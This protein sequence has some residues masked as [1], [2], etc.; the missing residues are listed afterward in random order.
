MG[1]IIG[2]DD[3]NRLGWEMSLGEFLDAGARRHSDKMFV[4]ISGHKVSYREFQFGARQTASMFRNMGIGHGD[5]VCLLLP[6]CL[7]FLLCWFGLSILGAITVPINTAYKRNEVAHILNHTGAKILVAHESLFPVGGDAAELARNLNHKLV[8]GAVTYRGKSWHR[9][10]DSLAQADA[11]TS[12]PEISP[13][14]IS[15]LVYTSGTTGA[16]KG[17]QVTHQM[18]VAAGQGFAHWTHAN[19]QDRFF[20]FL[21]FCHANPQYYS[22]MGTLAVGATLVVVD[23]FNASEFWYQARRAKATVAT[24]IGMAMSVLAKQPESPLDR[25]NDIRVIY[26]SPAFSPDYLRAFEERFGTRIVIGYGMT[27]S[28]YGTIEK[29]GQ[30][31][32][33]GASGQSRQHPDHRFFNQLRIVGDDGDPANPNTLG[34]I[35]M[36]NP[37]TT[38]GYWRN[39][40]L[41]RQNLR[42][43]W[44]YTGDLGYLDEEGFLYFFDRKSDVIRRQGE[45]ISSHEVESVI[46]GHPGV[47]DCAVIGVPS[48][49]RQDEVKAYVVPHADSAL[50][51]EEIVSWCADQLVSFKVPRYVEMRDDLPRTPSLR[52]RKDLL[53]REYE[54]LTQD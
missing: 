1:S 32:R 41:T 51:S 33:P 50:G 11:L 2:L 5:R 6:N 29:I 15:M 12:E 22:T 30:A 34:E 53:R 48:T 19:S 54:H 27:E 44:L 40:E 25:Q 43:G 23:Q 47:F 14:D 31:R 42:D 8:V 7:E 38:P 24:F 36:R 18:Y 3:P 16:P 9:F 39:G 17:V 52:V 26:S 10:S 13:R 35:A 20:A 28:C 49:S 45:I 4:E 21:P 46:K 37:A